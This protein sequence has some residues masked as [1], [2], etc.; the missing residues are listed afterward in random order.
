MQ[1]L[2][3]VVALD[4]ARSEYLSAC[5]QAELQE[6]AALS[7]DRPQPRIGRERELVVTPGRVDAVGEFKSESE[8]GF[9]VCNAV[10]ITAATDFDF[11]F[12]PVIG[13][14][15]GSASKS[16]IGS[17]SEPSVCFSAGT[18]ALSLSTSG[19][20]LGPVLDQVIQVNDLDVVG[21]A[22]V[23]DLKELTIPLADLDV[24]L[25]AVTGDGVVDLTEVS[26]GDFLLATATVLTN[27]GSAD[28]VLQANLLNQIA[29]RADDLSLTLDD[30]LALGTTGSSGLDA[31][32]NA[33]DL[34]AAAIVA[35]NGVNALKIKDLGISLPG[36]LVNGST[37][38]VLI[39]P[40]Q[41]ACGPVGT[42]A[43]TAQVR[44]DIAKDINA[45]G[46]T[47]AGLSMGV[48]VAQGT[49]ELTDVRCESPEQTTVRGTTGLAHVVARKDQGQ[50]GLS[51]KLLGLA[52]ANVNLTGQVGSNTTTH[53]FP[54][55]PAPDLKQ[56]YGGTTRIIVNADVSGLGGLL[57][58]L[59]V[60][61]NPILDTVNALTGTLDLLLKPVLAALGIQVGSMDVMMLGTPQ[62]NNVRLAG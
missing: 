59:N 36:D 15:S 45:I 14:D 30:I 43:R 25:S 44:V 2:A 51:V 62:C 23:V 16:A 38:L 55:P 35:A 11:A 20:A 5:D 19:S 29:A 18:K 60:L 49:A 39:E 52:L 32:V 12:A 28:A 8:G 61:L 53:D 9:S 7:L 41:I 21:Y 48:E 37:E 33:L 13:T 26:L 4:T 47:S 31:D 17:R 56:H 40:P 42:K 54:Y 27:Q 3:D 50:S 1:V 22:G 57:N 34:V 46:L 24:A 6:R 10:R 58:P